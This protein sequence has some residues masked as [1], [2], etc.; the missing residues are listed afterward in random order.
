MWNPYNQR[1]K[2]SLTLLWTYISYAN[3]FMK[4][5]AKKAE[6]LHFLM[7]IYWGSCEFSCSARSPSVRSDKCE[8]KEKEVTLEVK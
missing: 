8:E 6:I 3:S 1:N 5:W 4:T 2:W 7:H